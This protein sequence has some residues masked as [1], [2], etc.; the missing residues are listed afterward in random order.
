M[1]T[2]LTGTRISDTYDSLLKATDNGIITSSAKQITDGVGN[3]TPLYISTSRIGIGVSPTTTFQVSGNSKIG[4]DLTVTGNL[5]VEGTTTTVDTDT[6]SVKDPLII[7]GNDNNTSDLVDLGFYGLYDTSGSQDLYAGLYRS[8]SDTKFHLFKDLQEEPTTTVNTSG[9]GYAV[10]SLVANLEGNVTGNVTGG[11]I[12]G[13]TGT[14]SGDVNVNSNFIVTT[15]TATSAD[16]NGSHVI[17]KI[18]SSAGSDT[19]GLEIHT[20]DI[21]GD[22]PALLHTNYNGDEAFRISS[23]GHIISTGNG[24]FTG[25][26]SASFFKGDVYAND[27]TSKILENGTDGTDATFTGDVTGGLTGDVTGDITGNVTGN[28]TGD[29]TGD[30]TGNVTGDLTG[31]VTGDITGDVTGDI[32]GNVTATSVLADGV[33]ATTQSADDNSTKVATTAYVDALEVSST[34]SEILDNG[35][36]SGANDI[37]MADLRKIYFGTDSDFELSHNT[38]GNSIIQHLGTGTLFIRNNT[39]EQV[40]K[41]QAKNSI[42]VVNDYVIINGETERT[43]F[44]KDVEIKN[45]SELYFHDALEIWHNAN[46]SNII[47]N[48]GDL[49]ITQKTDDGDIIF[50][51]DDGS[52]DVTEYFRV[53]GDDQRVIYGRSI[54]MADNVSVY[55]GNTIANDGYIKWDSTANELFVNGPVKVLETLDVDG[56]STFAGNVEIGNTVASSMDAGANNL[57]IGTG[58]GTEGMTIYSGTAN[59]GTIYFADGASGDDRFRGQIGYSHSDNAF[60]FRTNASSSSNMTI[61][62]SG[63]S[64]FAGNV[65]VN[66]SG[67]GKI[68]VGGTSGLEIIHNNAGNTIAEIKQL[69]ASTSNAAQLKLTGGFTTFHTGTSGTERMRIDSSGNSTFAGNVTVGTGI[70]KA[71]IGGDIAITQGAIGLRLNDAASA[72]SP[73]NAT[74]NNDNAIDLGVSNIRFRNLYMGGTG[75]FGGNVTVNGGQDALTINTTDSDGPYAVWKNT[76]NATL[77]YVGNANSLAS[78]GDTN[79]CVRATNDLVFAAGGGTERMRIDSSGNVTIKAPTASGGGVLNLENTTTAVNGTDWGSLNFISNDSSTS[80]SGIRASV[81]GTS[82]SFNGDGN[83]VFST[84]PSNGTN[85]ERMRLTSGGDLHVDGDVVAYS[86]TISDK[87]LKDNVK[88]LESSLDKVMNL[89]GVEYVW[90]NGSRKGQKDIGFI[91]QEVEEVIPEIVREKQVIFNKEEK[92]KTVDY[93]KITA[94]LVEAVKELKAELEVLKNKPCACNNCNCK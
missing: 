33:T 42:D 14:F 18:D 88:P 72:I 49:I 92:Y 45:G 13:T 38:S 52:G 47:N 28:V 55:F 11:S 7:V 19:G 93:E 68:T 36:T 50:K 53:D 69:Y 81:V 9:T 80:A 75:T 91:A 64:T 59:S 71:S 8:A 76:T 66:N 74:S 22:E 5:L 54:Q 25:S 35:N 43:E 3:N 15:G 30:L 44:G 90:N 21:N 83:L 94:I 2:T 73:T 40:I 39:A 24:T 77:G 60:S 10:A 58:T 41:L 29:V 31:N 23:L 4:G 56:N 6:L 82:T 17:A 37:I 65:T 12:S 79:F 32:T 70:I 51:S 63:N 86:T 62:S 84:A 85:T 16:P 46:N 20:G 61:D 27:G 67:D 26:L 1:G 57:V 89:K 48:T 87:R 78:A 34:L